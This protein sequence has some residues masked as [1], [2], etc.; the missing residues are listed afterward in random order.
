MVGRRALGSAAST[1]LA[2]IGVG[3]G[4]LAIVRPVAAH[5]ADSLIP[6]QPSDILLDWTFDPLIAIPLFVA[7]IAYVWAVRRV[8]REHP[9]NPVP[10]IRIVT[11]IAGLLAIE[12][13]LQ[14]IVERY[15]TTFFS[16]HMVQ[17]LLLTLIAPPLLALGAPVTLLLRVSR[18]GFR[19][20]FLLPIL[21]SRVASVLSF[22]VFTWFFFAG[23][24]WATHFSPIFERSLVDPGVHDAE[25]ALYL[26]A[27]ILFWWPAVALDPSPW[28]MSHPAR[29]LYTG[30]QMP[31]NTFLAFVIL[32]A[33]VP[34]YAHYANLNLPWGP[35]A[36]ADQQLAGAIMWI[37]G[38]LVFMFSMILMLAGWMRSEAR[39]EKRSER[40]ADVAMAAIHERELLLADRLARER[41]DGET[42]GRG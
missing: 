36:V 35:T 13:A 17:H 28:R 34:L 33:S 6:P 16:V 7:G 37:V 24:M 10:R 26:T 9:A 29:M 19:Q 14:S 23:V 20:R 39:E 38:D 15:D 21:H 40:Q 2:V 11:F 18:P 22:P 1:L 12:I 32:N 27:G 41:A 5:G 8:D 42:A 3:V 31:Q 4:W 25:H 30:L